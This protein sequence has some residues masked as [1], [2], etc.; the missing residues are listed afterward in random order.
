MSAALLRSID[1][2]QLFGKLTKKYFKKGLHLWILFHKRCSIPKLNVWL[3]IYKSNIWNI[4]KNA[5][6][7]VIIFKLRKNVTFLCREKS[8][9]NS[10]STF[11]EQVSNSFAHFSKKYLWSII[12]FNSKKHL[13]NNEVLTHWLIFSSIRASQNPQDEGQKVMIFMHNW[14]HSSQQITYCDEEWPTSLATSSREK[15]SD[16]AHA[17]TFGLKL[18]RLCCSIFWYH[19]WNKTFQVKISYRMYFFF[20]WDGEVTKIWHRKMHGHIKKNHQLKQLYSWESISSFTK[21]SIEEKEERE[22]GQEKNLFSSTF[23][24][25]RRGITK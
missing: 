17:A 24:D 6:K 23:I 4:W 16:Q 14:P 20:N 25:W 9:Y 7:Y 10:H 21:F 5:F 19:E 8:P 22:R 3:F 2:I 12:E 18:K 1:S 13:A 15:I 11:L